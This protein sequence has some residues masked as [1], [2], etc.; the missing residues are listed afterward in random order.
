MKI[1]VTQEHINK[2]ISGDMNKCP[3]ALAVLEATHLPSLSVSTDYV[4]I[5]IGTRKLSR[6][7]PDEVKE[8][9]T[10]FDFHHLV[11]PFE[12]ELEVNL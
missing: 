8:F 9:I 6:K 5:D 10:A 3:I 11:K 7:L 1:K 4:I 12:F 2:G